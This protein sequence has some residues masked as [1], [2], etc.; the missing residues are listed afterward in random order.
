RD[1]LDLEIW[2]TTKREHVC[3]LQGHDKYITCIA[4]SPNENAILSMSLDNTVRFWDIASRREV[5]CLHI[6]DLHS[7]GTMAITRDG[8]L[9]VTNSG[10]GTHISLLDTTNGSALQTF[11]A[12]RDAAI[13][14]L[15]FS[16]N[17]AHVASVCGDFGFDDQR[18]HA[19][20][21]IWSV[22]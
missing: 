20:F 2:D 16:P 6:P 12:H 5:K 13:T 7:I 18:G 21:A 4:F 10:H 11:E 8:K 9:V 3:Q 17:G 22:R 14:R 1:G 15:R 19:E